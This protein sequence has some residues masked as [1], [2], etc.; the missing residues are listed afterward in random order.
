MGNLPPELLPI[1]LRA[2]IVIGFVMSLVPLLTW[3]ERKVV[4]DMQVRIGPNR[5]GPF[6]LLQPLADGLKLLFKEE[7]IPTQADKWVYLLA[8]AVAMVPALISVAIIPFGKGELWRVA[9]VNV[10]ILYI[11]A[12]TSLSVYGIVLAGWSSNSKWSLLGGLR[13]SAQM[14]SYE[15]TMGLAVAS[16]VIAAGTLR[17]PQFVELQAGG[18]LH[19]LV[20]PQFVSFLALFIAGLAETNRAPFDLPEAESELVAGYHTEYTGFKFLMFTLGE[21]S[22]IFTVSAVLSTLFLGGWQPPFPVAPFTWLPGPVWLL[23][24][25]S[26]IIFIFMWLRATLPRFRYD[27]LMAFGWKFMLPVTLI[28]LA[29]TAAWVALR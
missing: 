28:N 1:V 7:I 9:D 11:L 21:Y 4:A 20:I 27:Q 29:V 13:S 12:V 2:A 17:L 24:K 22:A 15:L 5:A 16:V 19:W 3:A 26:V 25:C 10:G 8:P 6:G 18:V 23:L 14:I